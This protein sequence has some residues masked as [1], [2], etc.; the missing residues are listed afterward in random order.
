MLYTNEAH[1]QVKVTVD[2]LPALCTGLACDYE[3]SEPTGEVTSMV[4]SDL[5]VT[6]TGTNLPL[7]MLSVTLAQTNCGVSSNTETQIVCALETP[8]VAGS[9]LPEV[10]DANGL[11]PVSGA[12]AAHH[13]PLVITAVSPD[14]DLNQAG[15]DVLTIT[16]ENF[17]STLTGH[18]LKFQF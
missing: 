11:I 14:I 5:D 17:P 8:W 12:V 6:L 1:P 16:G 7:D 13:V 9:W 15:G 18:D 10:R 4:I 3:Y 2:G